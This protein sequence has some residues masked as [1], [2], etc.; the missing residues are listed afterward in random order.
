M[1]RAP[2]TV[3]AGGAR[4]LL[5]ATRGRIHGRRRR[6]LVARGLLGGLRLATL[7]ADQQ[8]RS[9]A[10]EHHAF[11]RPLHIAHAAILSDGAQGALQ[12]AHALGAG[13]VVESIEGRGERGR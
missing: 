13:Q 3:R 4:A 10:A 9:A 7:H 8:P 11:G 2:G 1:F 5:R 6:G 12:L